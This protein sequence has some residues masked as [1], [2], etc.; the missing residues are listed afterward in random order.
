MLLGRKHAAQYACMHAVWQ[1]SG[2]HNSSLR[3][4]SACTTCS[5]YYDHH[6]R[7]MIMMIDDSVQS[8]LLCVTH[9][10]STAA[11]C[12]GSKRAA[13]C[14]PLPACGVYSTFLLSQVEA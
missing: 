11:E 6:D 5:S 2:R 7:M 9:S 12:T 1:L 14:L 8:C 3:H 4:I 13:V 10:T